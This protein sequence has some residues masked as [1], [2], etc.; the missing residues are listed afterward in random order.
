MS[1]RWNC[2]GIPVTHDRGFSN[3]GIPIWCGGRYDWV[4]AQMAVER[5]RGVDTSCYL[6]SHV[7]AQS[8]DTLDALGGQAGS[9]GGTSSGG[10]SK[11]AT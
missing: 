4:A 11:A 6:T 5:E 9:G 7:V 3:I 10:E 2:R 1:F 8:T